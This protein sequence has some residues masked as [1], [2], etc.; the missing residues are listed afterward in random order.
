PGAD[1]AELSLED[2]RKKGI[3][4][5]LDAIEKIVPGKRIHAN[6]YCL[7]GTLLAI[8]AAVMSRDGD[9]RLASITLMAAQVDF[10]EAGEL[11][12]F[13]DDSQVAF[14]EDLMWT[15]GYLD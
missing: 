6:G 14:I 9:D 12:L 1:Q 7:G 4:A 10:A 11:L 13:I 8:A 15:Q 2:Y 5:A 3:M